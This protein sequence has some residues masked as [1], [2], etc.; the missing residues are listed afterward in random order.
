MATKTDTVAVRITADARQFK[1]EIRATEAATRR[2]GRDAARAMAPY[3]AAVKR[4]TADLQRMQA[5][6]KQAAAQAAAAARQARSQIAAGYGRMKSA[7]STAVGFGGIAGAVMGIRDA[8]RFE[9]ALVQLQ[10]QGKKTAAWLDKARKTIIAVSDDTGRAKDEVLSYLQGIVEATGDADFAVDSLRQMGEVAVATGAHMGDLS[11]AMEKA[12]GSF[13]LA[14]KDSMALWNIW[15]QQ[16]K[17][18]SVTVA[19]ISREIGKIAGLAP[20]FGK[21]GTG[22][23]GAKAFGGLI[24]LAARGFGKDQKGEAATATMRFLQLLRDRT[25]KDPRK[26]ARMLGLRVE[27][28]GRVTDSGFE[29]NDLS[30]VFRRIAEAAARDPTRVAKYGNQLF[31]RLGIRVYEQLRNAAQVGWTNSSGPYAAAAA[32]F[33]VGNKPLIHS[34]ASVIRASRA[35]KLRRAMTRLQNRFYET[36]LPAMEKLADLMPT[37]AKGISWTLGHIKELVTVWLGSKL[38]RV[39]GSIGRAMGGTSGAPMAGGVPVAGGGFGG[40]LTRG[41]QYA[42]AGLFAV[43]AGKLLGEHLAGVTMAEMDRRIKALR[44]ELEVGR[45][46]KEIAIKKREAVAAFARSPAWSTVEGAEAFVGAQ[47]ILQQLGL[48]RGGAFAP[49]RLLQ[50][51]GFKGA[52]ALKETL[53]ARYQRL[54]AATEAELRKR[55]PKGAEIGRGSVEAAVPQLAALRTSME[56]LDRRMAE[57]VT[58]TRSGKQVPVQVNVTVTVPDPTRPGVR[59]HVANVSTRRAKVSGGGA[60]QY[61]LAEAMVPGGVGDMMRVGGFLSRLF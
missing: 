36:M 24:Q 11:G 28:L 58:G 59:A 32:I 44:R 57:I 26:V 31:G 55:L 8:Q 17:L 4:T 18:G 25:A 45:Q 43:T 10:V 16:E 52:R 61:G 50:A 41:S 35:F 2:L 5:T 51:R 13:R 7:I 9:A 30:Q 48:D 33:G 29:F 6:A 38:L 46:R 20:G 21:H 42:M 40:A 3:D 37:I 54:Y 60:D 23:A 15:R 34:D 27:D 47:G 1:R 53:S 39:L 12:A 14:A 56:A 19:D 22:L 49:D